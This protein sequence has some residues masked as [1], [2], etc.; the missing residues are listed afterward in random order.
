MPGASASIEGQIDFI[1]QHPLDY[2]RVLAGSVTVLGKS[3]LD[4]LGV[5]GWLDTPLNPLAMHLFF[6]FLVIV[7]LG[8]RNEWQ[9]SLRLRLTALA[10][11]A[12]CTVIMLTSLYV[13]GNP[14]GHKVI[15]GVQGRYFL[16]LLPLLLLTL[17]NRWIEVR[18]PELLRTWTATAGA[19]I[20]VVA[21][22]G[23]VRRD[24]FPPDTQLWMSPVALAAAFLLIAGVTWWI[25]RNGTLLRSVANRPDYETANGVNARR[26]AV[27]SG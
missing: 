15:V 23:V 19:A 26:S 5:L 16:P 3:W 11:A 8:D 27:T 9:P 20:L 7:A 18:G 12:V 10:T 2:L 6:I 21:L 14:V 1:T 17:S 13:C 25:R 4:Q 22:A 24:Y